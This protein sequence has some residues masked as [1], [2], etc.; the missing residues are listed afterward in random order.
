MK[1]QFDDGGR[2]AAGF[3]GQAGDCVTRAIA[4]ATGKPYQEVYDQINETA[5]S[6]R[7]SKR[8]RGKSNARTGVHKDVIRQYLEAL[9]WEWTPTMQI[10]SGC[11]VHLRADELPPGRLIVNLS[12]HSAAV[13]DGVLHDTHDC[14]RDGTRCVYGYFREVVRV[15]V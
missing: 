13:I 10:G 2:A 6:E 11:K 5:R 1:F 7:P 8:K 3:K 14:S 12:R 4:I 9:G 15:Q